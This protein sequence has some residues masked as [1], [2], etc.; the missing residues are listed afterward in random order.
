MLQSVAYATR[1]RNGYSGWHGRASPA[2]ADP[3]T[4]P[5]CGNSQRLR[6]SSPL[7]RRTIGADQAVTGQDDV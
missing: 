6:S 1:I 3:I 2:D 5:S 7:H 4:T